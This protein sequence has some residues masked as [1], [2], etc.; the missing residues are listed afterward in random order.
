MKRLI[1]F[2]VLVLFNLMLYQGV[3]K[4]IFILSIIISIVVM[5]MN[6]RKIEKR[7]LSLRY[8][9]YFT[10]YVLVLLRE[11]VKSNFH[12]ANI[13]LKKKVDISPKIITHKIDL[14]MD[15]HKVMLS[16]SI[17]LTPGTLTIDMK[18]DELI[19]HCLTEKGEDSVRDNQ[20]ERILMKMEDCLNG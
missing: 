9:A 5:G 19:V 17:T 7:K 11:I 20:I 12:V 6:L 14:K 16:N 10:Y 13:M 4:E 3:N 1:Y 18:D 15:S 2:I 8:I